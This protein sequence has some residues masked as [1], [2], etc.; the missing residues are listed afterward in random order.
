MACRVPIL[1]QHDVA[2]PAGQFTPSLHK[3]CWILLSHFVQSR[4]GLQQLVF[5]GFVRRHRQRQFP[6]WSY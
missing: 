4:K 6:L 2:E 5:D 3:F 1:R